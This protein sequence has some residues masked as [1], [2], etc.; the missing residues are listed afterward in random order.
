[1]I[2]AVVAAAGGVLA[3][4]T[5]RNASKRPAED[6]QDED[7]LCTP[8]CALDASSLRRGCAAQRRDA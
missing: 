6:V 1:M 5:I 3:A 2:A 7:A 8:H 4:A